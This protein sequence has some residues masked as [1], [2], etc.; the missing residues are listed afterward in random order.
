MEGG[1]NHSCRSMPGPYPSLRGD[2]AKDVG[3]KLHGNLKGKSSTMLYEQFGELK[4]KFRNRAFWCRGYYVD[5]VGKNESRIAE[6]IKNQLK[7]DE[8]GE[9][10]RIPSASPFTGSK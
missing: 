5:T 3:I 1:K 2:T 4:Y 9:Q 7:E 6:Y 8:M 10:L